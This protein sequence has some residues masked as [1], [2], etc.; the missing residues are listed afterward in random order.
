M[1]VRDT[2]TTVGIFATYYNLYLLFGH[3]LS[4]DVFIA[5][6]KQ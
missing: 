4:L 6:I 2:S 3:I 5:L 1:G